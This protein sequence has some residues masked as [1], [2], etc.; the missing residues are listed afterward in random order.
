MWQIHVPNSLMLIREQSQDEEIYSPHKE[1][2]KRL[3]SVLFCLQLGTFIEM[4]HNFYSYEK[5][6]AWKEV[7]LRGKYSLPS[8]I[9]SA[10]ITCVCLDQAKRKKFNPSSW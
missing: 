6:K 10:S 9:S 4:T 5:K 2:L 3:Y 8:P 1:M 7:K